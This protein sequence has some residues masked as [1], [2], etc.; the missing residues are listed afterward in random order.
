MCVSFST[1]FPIKVHGGY[2]GWQI[3]TK[4]DPPVSWGTHFN[5]GQT[6]DAQHRN[7][8]KSKATKTGTNNPC[9]S[10]CS[11]K[12]SLRCADL[13][14][15]KH[16]SPHSDLKARLEPC[17]TESNY[18]PNR[19]VPIGNVVWLGCCTTHLLTHGIDFPHKNNHNLTTVSLWCS[20]SV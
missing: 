7:L 11:L 8:T 4:Q 15:K 16:S 12:M 14:T 9:P 1:W 20:A 3:H 17:F 10:V 13:K 19:C 6:T 18:I 5:R 2:N